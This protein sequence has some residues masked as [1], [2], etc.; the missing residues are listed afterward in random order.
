[1]NIKLWANNIYKKGF[2]LNILK[3]WKNMENPFKNK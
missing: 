2:L 3:N 1:M